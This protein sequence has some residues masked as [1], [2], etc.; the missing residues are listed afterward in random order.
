VVDPVEGRPV[1]ERKRLTMRLAVVAFGYIVYRLIEPE[2]L[3]GALLLGFGVWLVGVGRVER[4]LNPQSTDR[5]R[6]LQ[7]LGTR[8]GIAMIVVGTVLAVI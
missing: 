5:Q 4:K 2:S 3:I 1:D 8:V 6:M 7:T